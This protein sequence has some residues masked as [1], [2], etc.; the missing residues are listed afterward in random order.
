MII[1][2]KF[3]KNPASNLGGDVLKAI[4]SNARGTTNNGQRTSNDHNSSP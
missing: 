2:T 4:V 1:P 3:G